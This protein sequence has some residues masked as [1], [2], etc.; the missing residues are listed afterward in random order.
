MAVVSLPWIEARTVC[1][2][3]LAPTEQR[4][5]SRS[6]LVQLIG[7]T[8]PAAAAAAAAAASWIPPFPFPD[9]LST[10]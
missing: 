2:P 8:E 1:T 5:R 4:Q 9:V 6:F 10:R 3:A 7:E